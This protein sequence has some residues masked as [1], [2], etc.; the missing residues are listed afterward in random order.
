MFIKHFCYT[1]AASPSLQH[2]N[3]RH[4]MDK[5]ELNRH[6]HFSAGTS[7]YRRIRMC[8]LIEQEGHIR[9]K[10]PALYLGLAVES[11]HD[12]L[13]VDIALVIRDTTYVMDF[14]LQQVAL[15]QDAITDFII[16]KIKRYVHNNNVKII[17]AGL[18]WT[19]MSLS[20]RLCSRLW[21][22]LDIIPVV[23]VL[24]HEMLQRSFSYTEL[25][26]EQAD[27]LAR[28]CMLLVSLHR[29]NF[30]IRSGCWCQ[31]VVLIKNQEFGT[32]ASPYGATWRSRSCA[33]GCWIPC[34]I[35]HCR[36]LQRYLRAIY[37]ASN[38]DLCTGAPCEWYQG[39]LFQQH[40]R[41]QPGCSHASGT[42]SV[43]TYHGR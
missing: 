42:C 28:Q 41:V 22:D 29:F 9:T 26:D 10:L 25:I 43:L 36:R 18:P 8:N 38:D 33:D 39:C 2:G 1:Q 14:S 7:V 27:D 23:V 17:G 21:L 24:D 15:N 32:I 5:A 35:H 6:Q 20:P 12:K 40:F 31:I 13:T 37:L 19:L 11:G 34:S 30:D 3:T 16:T 4:E